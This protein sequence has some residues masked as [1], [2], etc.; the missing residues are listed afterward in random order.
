MI[1][2]NTNTDEKRTLLDALRGE[3]G[4][5]AMPNGMTVT[6]AGR[7]VMFW[8][9]FPAGTEAVEVPKLPVRFPLLLSGDDGACCVPVEPSAGFVGVPEAFRKKRF[10]ASGF[11]LLND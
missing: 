6:K 11:A 5:S 4:T 9:A 1:R 8:G 2:I 3:Y 10:V 7:I